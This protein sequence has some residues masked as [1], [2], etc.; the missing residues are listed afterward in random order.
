VEVATLKAFGEAHGARTRGR[1]GALRP[2]AAR[3]SARRCATPPRCS[4]ASPPATGCSSSSPTAGPT[5]PTATP[6]TP[7]S[8]TRARRCSRR[9]PPGSCPS[10]SPID[11]EA[12]AYVASVFGATGFAV[13]RDPERLPDALVGAVRQLLRG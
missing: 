6:G 3:G 11:R 8:R 4:P 2:A 10:A 13:L 5:T 12:P 1:I 9:A 7:P